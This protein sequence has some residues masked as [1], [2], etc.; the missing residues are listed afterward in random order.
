VLIVPGNRVEAVR[1]AA[2]RRLGAARP[3]SAPRSDSAAQA[4]IATVNA[5]LNALVDE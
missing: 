3:V 2:V 4:L 1:G 5:R